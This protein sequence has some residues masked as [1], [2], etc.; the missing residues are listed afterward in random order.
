MED[1]QRFM[2]YT[3]FFI[4]LRQNFF[5]FQIQLG[6]IA[7]VQ[8]I[9]KTNFVVRVEVHDHFD[10]SKLNVIYPIRILS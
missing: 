3:Y 6:V 7:I 8:L 9:N 2:F 10:N 1:T 5:V 4:K